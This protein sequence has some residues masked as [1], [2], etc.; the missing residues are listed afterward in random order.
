MVN[1][2]TI[3]EMIYY[4]GGIYGINKIQLRVKLLELKELLDL[5]DVDKRISNLS[6]GEKRR[7]SFACAFVHDPELAVLDEPTVGLDPL[8][9]EKYFE[10]NCS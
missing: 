10:F 8:L 4:F 9:R 1:E 5:A 7:V 2:L 3:K 6:G